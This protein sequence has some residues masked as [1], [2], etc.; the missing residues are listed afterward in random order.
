MLAHLISIFAPRVDLDDCADAAR[1]S[2]PDDQDQVPALFRHHVCFVE[3]FSF[4][5]EINAE[6]LR[7]CFGSRCSGGEI[8]LI[9]GRRVA[10]GVRGPSRQCLHAALAFPLLLSS[11]AFEESPAISS[12]LH[13]GLLLRA[14]ASVAACESSHSPRTSWPFKFVPTSAGERVKATSP[15]HQKAPCPGTIFAVGRANPT[16]DSAAGFR[17]APPLQGC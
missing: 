9:R 13:D 12:L 6:T 2:Q 15:G 17:Q 16:L 14:I 10:M 11:V 8:A 5:S 7:N 3:G 1:V 4:A